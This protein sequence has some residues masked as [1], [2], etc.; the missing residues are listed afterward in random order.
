M[1][2][3]LLASRISESA[4]AA[5]SMRSDSRLISAVEG[6]AEKIA[7][8]YKGGGKVILFG[9]GGSASQAL[10]IAA[11]FEGKYLKQRRA[12]PA[13]ALGANIASATAIGNDYD[14][15]HVFVRQ[16]EA[17]G[18]KGDVA[19]ALSTSGN[20]PNVVEAV[21]YS[22]S[23]GIF[24]AAFVGKGKCKLDGMASITVKVPSGQTPRIQEMHLL[25]L[26]TVCEMVENELFG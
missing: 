20:S 1:A 15:S 4:D 16:L 18:K 7:E 12:L 17:S 23:Q 3:G 22:K 11:E 6:I 24:T 14:F 19:I 9:N 5:R 21:K 10:H 25:L 2:D 13:L 26:H 8:C